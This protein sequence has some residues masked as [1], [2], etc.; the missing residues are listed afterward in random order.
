VIFRYPD[1]AQPAPRG[2]ALCVEV[3]DDGDEAVTVAVRGEVDIA[4][5]ELLYAGIQHGLHK[6]PEHLSVYL[7]DVSFFGA[8][9][10]HALLEARRRAQ[11][12]SA[13]LV[14]CAPS[15]PVLTVLGL[16]RL[17]EVFEIEDEL[18]PE[19]ADMR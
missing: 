2:S 8:T 5:V 9:G 10:L 15:R 12:Q 16:A 6:K 11:E 4:T 3:V 18:P 13:A 7:S 17:D 1:S 14:L 19:A